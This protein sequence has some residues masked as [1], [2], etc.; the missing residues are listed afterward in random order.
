MSVSKVDKSAIEKKVIEA[1]R[2]CFDPEIPVNIYDL[3]L[4]YGIEVDE[5]GKVDIK[6]TLT[7]PCCPV[8]GSL[9]AEVEPKVQSIPEVNDVDV[10][11][12]WE[13]TWNDSIR[14]E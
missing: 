6:M 3:G 8:A 5:T 12:I 7:S 10:N 1:L 14:F 9:P 11:M 4:I 2:K 13:L